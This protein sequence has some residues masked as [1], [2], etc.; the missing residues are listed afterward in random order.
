MGPLT[1]ARRQVLLGIAAVAG[2]LQELAGVRARDGLGE[3][4]SRALPSAI[5]RARPLELTAGS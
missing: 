4:M 1:G 5:E 3:R 2:W